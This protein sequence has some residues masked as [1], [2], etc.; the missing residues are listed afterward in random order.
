MSECKHKFDP[1]QNGWWQCIKC[2]KKLLPMGV[3]DYYAERI[4][5]TVQDR[6]SL[7]AQI[8]V[9][10][11]ILNRLVKS[12]S[13]IE[14]H[15]KSSMDA[16]RCNGSHQEFIREDREDWQVYQ[17]AK[18]IANQ[19]ASNALSTTPDAGER[20]RLLIKA[21]TDISE[22]SDDLG[23]RECASKALDKYRG[24]ATDAD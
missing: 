20:V 2:E 15:A 1:L 3:I 12:L 13:P 22:E 11:G 19:S 5:N 14:K 10:C 23:A 17:K 7:Q 6:D 18:E 21:L 24:G 9:L 16:C 8:R 4:A